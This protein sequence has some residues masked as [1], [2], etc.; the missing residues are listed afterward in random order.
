MP[1]KVLEYIEEIHQ[2]VSIKDPFQTPLYDEILSKFYPLLCASFSIK[3]F[4][5]CHFLIYFILND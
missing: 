5:C 2:S 4:L 1:L 3:I